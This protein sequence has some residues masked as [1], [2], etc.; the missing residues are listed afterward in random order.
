MRVPDLLSISP[1]RTAAQRSAESLLPWTWPQAPRLEFETQRQLCHL[2]VV[3]LGFG[4]WLGSW[5][6]RR[7]V[8]PHVLS[9][10]P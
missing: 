5:Q 9:R 10:S 2:L 4:Y 3:S 7:P 6:C 8:L 1:S